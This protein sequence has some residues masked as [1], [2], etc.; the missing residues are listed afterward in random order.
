M[1][2]VM[3]SVL[4]TE[5]GLVGSSKLYFSAR[6]QSNASQETSYMNLG[7]QCYSYCWWESQMS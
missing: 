7:Y 1:R 6:P 5:Y 3:P 2:L 4:F